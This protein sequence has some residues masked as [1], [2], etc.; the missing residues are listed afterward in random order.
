MKSFA[1]NLGIEFNQ[2]ISEPTI[3]GRL[4]GG[5]SHYGKSKGVNVETL[6]NYKKV[7]NSNEVDIIKKYVGELREEILSQKSSFLDLT[8]IK[9]NLFNDIYYQKN[10]SQI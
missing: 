2:I 3:G 6:N 10:I 1:D 8:K 5:N 4:W 7:L 9:E